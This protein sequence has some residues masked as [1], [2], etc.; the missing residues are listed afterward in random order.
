ME[1]SCIARRFST[2]ERVLRRAS[3]T[4]YKSDGAV[5]NYKY[6]DGTDR[7]IRRYEAIV[8]T[9]E[10]LAEMIVNTIRLEIRCRVMC[11]VGASVR[12]RQVIP[13]KVENHRN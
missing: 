4:A 11:N 7:H 2:H 12:A 6:D 10:Q 8:Q 13:L 1:L 3:F 9:Y 5:S